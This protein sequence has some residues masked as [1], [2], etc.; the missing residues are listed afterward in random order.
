MSARSNPF[1]DNPFASTSLATSPFADPA[2]TSY[3]P[4]TGRSSVPVVPIVS[5]GAWG[6]NN[7]NA[8]DSVPAT[9]AVDRE[10]G[11]IEA[12]KR[13]E[14]LDAKEKALAAKEAE[15]KRWEADLRATG[16]LKPKKNWPS[17][18]CPIAHHDIAAEVPAAMQ[19]TVTKGYYSYLFLVVCMV[20]NCFG[21]LMALCVIG[22][23]DGRLSGW[24]LACI[25]MVAGVP[26]AW[27]AWYRRLYN[28]AIKD[29]A[30]TYAWFFIAYLIHIAF[31]VWSA[32]APPLPG[33]NAW[34]H[35]GFIACV[36]AFSASKFVGVLYTIGG[37]LWALESLWSLW[38]L[39]TVYTNFR[40][41]GGE[42]Q[43][44]REVA[45]SVATNA[46]ASAFTSRV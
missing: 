14:T 22:N 19:G 27:W 9:I 3:S 21:S 1:S 32:I 5:G 35:T 20:F 12:L 26:I 24:F 18:F 37:V 34:S 17:R 38:V 11:S 42:A 16:S 30:V 33:A 23:A 36:R 13:V 7:G 4:H 2:E 6:A 10:A 28:A 29:R 8:F 41:G 39:K 43:L 25:Y 44:R 31:C 15:L 45:R 46:A 40:G